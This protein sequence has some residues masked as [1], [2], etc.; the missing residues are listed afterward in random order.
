MKLAD[1]NVWLALALS[2]HEHHASVSS[3]FAS[4]ELENEVAFCRFTQLAFVRLLT[5]RAVLK[6]YGNPPLSNNQAWKFYSELLVDDRIGFVAEPEG[7]EPTW[8]RLASVRSA[9]P[10]LWM[11]AYLAAFAIAGGHRLVTIDNAFSQ[12][13]GLDLELLS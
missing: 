7:L 11:H 9:S 12:F 8:R 4:L 5:T 10:K 1:S 3:W 6:L 2:G 13:Q